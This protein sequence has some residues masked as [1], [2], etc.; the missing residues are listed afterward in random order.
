MLFDLGGLLTRDAD[1]GEPVKR[2]QLAL[3]NAQG[4]GAGI[5]HCSKMQPRY[6]MVLICPGGQGSLSP[7]RRASPSRP[8]PRDEGGVIGRLER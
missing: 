4:F 8:R 6:N 5:Q 3:S 2:Y 7:S 1:N